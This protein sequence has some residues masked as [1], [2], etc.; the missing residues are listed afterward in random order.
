MTLASLVASSI[1]PSDPASAIAV[2]ATVA[3]LAFVGFMA[4]LALTRRLVVVGEP[5]RRNC[6]RRLVDRSQ[7]SD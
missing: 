2:V 7:R 3:L 4:F 6:V 1:V 5:T